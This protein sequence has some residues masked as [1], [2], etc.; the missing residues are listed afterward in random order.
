MIAS[1]FCKA[2][3]NSDT[4]QRQNSDCMLYMRLRTDLSRL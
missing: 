1:I 2:E 3:E 4:A